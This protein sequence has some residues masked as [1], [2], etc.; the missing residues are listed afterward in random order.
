METAELRLRL[1]AVEAAVGVPRIPEIRATDTPAEDASQVALD[2]PPAAGSLAPLLGWAFLGLSGAYLLRGATESGTVPPVLGV[3]AGVIYAGLWLMVAA[4]RA[5]EKPL[6]STVYAATAALILTPLLWEATVRFHA[7][8]PK[9]ASAVLVLFAAFGVAIAW[10]HSLAGVAWA[11]IVGGVLTPIAIFRESHDGAAWAACAIAIAAVVEASAF[12]DRWP[13]LRWVAAMAADFTVLLLTYLVT[14]P[15]ASADFTQVATPQFLLGAQV[16]LLFVYLASTVGRTLVRRLP[17]QPFEIGQAAI[18]FVISVGGALWLAEATSLGWKPVGLF[19]AVAG[20]VCYTVSFAMLDRDTQ[21]SRNFYTYSTF[22]IL[23]SIVAS[24]LLFH[25]ESVAMA[26]SVVAVCMML[27]GMFARRRTLRVHGCVLLVLAGAAA[28]VVPK[29]WA[30]MVHATGEQ[31]GALG[32]SYAAVL[33]A[34]MVVY[35]AFVRWTVSSREALVPV[36]ILT[37]SLAGVLAAIAARATSGAPMRTVV[38]VMFAVGTAK[39]GS[40]VQRLELRWVA[41]GFVGLTGLKLLLADFQTAGSLGLF[42]SL[43]LFGAMLILV[44]RVARTSQTD[45]RKDQHAIGNAAGM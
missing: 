43:L 16:G 15:H 24:R 32:V 1:S 39:L 29:G 10:K 41:Y 34:A 30:M 8:V 7:F 5:W 21:P 2:R 42:A 11:A 40:S 4:R 3:F 37:W 9:S 18:A 26:W 17:I 22:G 28:G 27:A 14:V 20:A 38:L 6:T 19:C 31:Y 33:M 36:A 25:G 35:G 44:P 13:G 12:R 45:L 23:L